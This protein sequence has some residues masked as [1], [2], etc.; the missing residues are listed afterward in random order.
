[1]LDVDSLLA[2]IPG[3]SPGGPYLEYEPIGELERMAAGRAGQRLGDQVAP[4][5]EPDWPA[6]RDR[7]LQLFGQTHDLRVAVVLTRALI[8]TEGIAGLADG[9]QLI[10]A[11]LAR[12]WETVN[13]PLYLGP[14]REY[15]P[16]VRM[17]ALAPLAHG[18]GLVREVRNAV[19]V[20]GPL[21]RVTVRDVQVALGKLPAAAGEAG[22]G[23]AEVAAAIKAAPER[24]PTLADALRAAIGHLKA[25]HALLLGKDEPG[26]AINLAPVVEVLKSTLPACD[27]A[28]AADS[29]T[30]PVPAKESG[31]A[32]RGVI[33]DRDEAIHLLEAICQFFERTEP[34]NP[35]P[36][37]M[38]RAQ[39]LLNKSFVD[40]IQD[41]APDTLNRIE[42]IT[43]L[44]KKT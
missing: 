19:L 7:A 26:L 34:T 30:V 11:M 14:E 22:R 42:D 32:V 33:R 1:M 29:A 27:N 2:E 3:G 16:A 36:L 21:G 44:K 20:T 25:I 4:V 13:P 18:E 31:P 38:R 5:E 8:R 17:N 15:D 40:I 24:H 9:L 43:G 12:G 28:P 6:I 39:R 10:H 41:L 37:F 23:L 35:G